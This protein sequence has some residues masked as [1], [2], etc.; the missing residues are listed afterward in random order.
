MGGR[1]MLSDPS[2]K[3]GPRRSKFR[4]KEMREGRGITDEH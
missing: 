1:Y 3:V 2:E 4:K